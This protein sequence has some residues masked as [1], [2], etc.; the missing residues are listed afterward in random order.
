ME[1]SYFS[2]KRSLVD[3]IELSELFGF[4]DEHRGL[5]NIEVSENLKYERDAQR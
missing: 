5:D 4:I 2:F 3:P 1:R